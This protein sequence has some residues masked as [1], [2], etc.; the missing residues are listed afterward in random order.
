[1][2]VA[3]LAIEG[4]KLKIDVS[5]DVNETAGD[6]AAAKRSGGKSGVV[7][8]GGGSPK[9]FVLQ[10][11]PRC[12]RSSASRR[13]GTTTI[14]QFTDAR[15]DTAGSRARRR[16]RRSAGARS[17]RQLP[18]T[19]V[20]YCD[21]TIALPNPHRVRARRIHAPRKPKRLYER[22]E[23]LMQNLIHEYH[24]AHDFGP[25]GGIKSRCRA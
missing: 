12:R 25:D 22:R 23:A 14:L 4:C 24:A 10:T 20:C 21:S 16:A 9:N 15:V 1:M 11:E 6:R 18:D 8:L 7:M 2:N 19:V 3:A 5:R 17:T 13:K